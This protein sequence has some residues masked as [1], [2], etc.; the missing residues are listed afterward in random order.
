MQGSRASRDQRVTHSDTVLLSQPIHKCTPHT[1]H[2]CTSVCTTVQYTSVHL[3]SSSA[4]TVSAQRGALV[5]LTPG[6]GL[7][8]AATPLQKRKRNQ[9]VAHLSAVVSQQA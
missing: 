6:L 8:D 2:S 7:F 3:C 9:R 1:V 4:R 5:S